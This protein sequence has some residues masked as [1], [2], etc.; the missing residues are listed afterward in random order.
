MPERD[1]TPDHGD[2]PDPASLCGTWRATVHRLGGEPGLTTDIGML[3]RVDESGAVT[4]FV[5]GR[6]AQPGIGA[7]RSVGHGRV[8]VVVEWLAETT[9]RRVHERLSMHAAGE[10]SVDGR[11]CRLRMQWQLLARDGLPVG[12]A[13]SG[14]AEATRLDP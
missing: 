4:V 9:A 6:S 14:E 12:T 3:A 11:T 8:L 13:A 10:L 2:M 5:D 7:W 1:P